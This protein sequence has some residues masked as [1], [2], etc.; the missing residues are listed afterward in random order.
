MLLL[1]SST[2]SVDMALTFSL[3]EMLNGNDGFEMTSNT[4][5]SGS[6]LEAKKNISAAI[7]SFLLFETRAK[8]PLSPMM[9]II[10]LT[11]V[12]VGRNKG[13]NC[14]LFCTF[15]LLH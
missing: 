9:D 8:A 13:L 14:N 12:V 5:Q 11:S 4:R 3:Q 15:S 6:L 1:S 7:G 2:L 10:A